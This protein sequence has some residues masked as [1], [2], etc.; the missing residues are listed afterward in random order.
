LL[1]LLQRRIPPEVDF[2][3][4]GI[5]ARGTRE[6]STVEAPA[7]AAADSAHGVIVVIVLAAARPLVPLR[8]GGAHQP[9]AAVIVL[10]NSPS[11]GAIVDG[12]LVLD[13]LRVVAHASV[14]RTTPADRVWLMLCD[15]VLRGGTREALL[16]TIDSTRPAGCG[17]IWS[18]PSNARLAS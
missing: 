9:T 4:S 6:R 18:R 11:S 2:P 14:G 12:G 8:G 3:Q 7:P 1:H 15:G 16:A 5:S 17:W 10:D 13:R